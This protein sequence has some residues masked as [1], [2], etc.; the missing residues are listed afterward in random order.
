MCAQE[1]DY[2]EDDVGSDWEVGW[3]W[4]EREEWQQEGCLVV[5]AA[6]IG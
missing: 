2:G 5:E 6:V 3:V 4:Q 1:I